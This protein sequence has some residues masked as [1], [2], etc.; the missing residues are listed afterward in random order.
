MSEFDIEIRKDGTYRV[1]DDGKEERVG[2]RHRL[3]ELENA[4]GKDGPGK[5]GLANRIDNLEDDIETIKDEIG[6]S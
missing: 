1:F 4:V 5:R 6:L 2:D 3:E